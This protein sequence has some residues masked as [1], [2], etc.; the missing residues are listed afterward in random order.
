[1]PR[2]EQ[3]GQQFTAKEKLMMV[4]FGE[5]PETPEHIKEDRE[6][7]AEIDLIISGENFQKSLRQEVEQILSSLNPIENRVLLM[8]FGLEDGEVKTPEQVGITIGKSAEEVLKIEEKALHKL[9]SPQNIETLQRHI[10]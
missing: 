4:V 3:K 5:S 10:E 8:R 6:L 9:R 2:K 7:S 1:M